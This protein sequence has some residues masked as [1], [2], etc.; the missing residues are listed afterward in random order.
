M[1]PSVV[2]VL[3]MG[4][5]ITPLVSPWSTTTRRESKTL[6]RGRSVI[7]SQESCW[8]GQ[9]TEG[10]MGVSGGTVGWVLALFC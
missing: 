6:E 1:I 7:K 3:L 2:K 10:L 5:R 8:N 4:H 9:E